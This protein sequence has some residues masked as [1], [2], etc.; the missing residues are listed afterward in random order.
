MATA[1]ATAKATA[2]AIAKTDY[3]TRWSLLDAE[4][5]RIEA[6]RKEIWQDL[7]EKEGNSAAKAAQLLGV[8]SGQYMDKKYSVC[9]K[10]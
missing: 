1:K 9:L 3:V 4:Q 7:R 2:T 8:R 6:E 10:F 5:D